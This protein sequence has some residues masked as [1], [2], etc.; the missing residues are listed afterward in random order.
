MDSIIHSFVYGEGLF[1]LRLFFFLAGD[2]FRNVAVVTFPSL[3]DEVI[4]VMTEGGPGV[5]WPSLSNKETISSSS[6]PIFNFLFAD[7][8]LLGEEGGADRKVDDTAPD[9]HPGRNPPFD[10]GAPRCSRLVEGCSACEGCPSESINDTFSSGE[11]PPAR[12][13]AALGLLDII[14]VHH[15]LPKRMLNLSMLEFL[16]S[17]TILFRH[18]AAESRLK[19]TNQ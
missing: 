7:A 3:A 18:L 4:V 14:I 17:S 9:S 8:S 1:F 13:L 2:P 16:I 15:E 6:T 10:E 5:G 12:F 11:N 19:P